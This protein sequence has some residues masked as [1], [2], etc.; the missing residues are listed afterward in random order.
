LH[1]FQRSVTVAGNPV[2]ELETGDT[3]RQAVYIGAR[4]NEQSFENEVQAG[5]FTSKLIAQEVRLSN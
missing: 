1:C 3:D 4:D 2:L 5:D